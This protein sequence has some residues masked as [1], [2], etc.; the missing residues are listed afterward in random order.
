MSR[1]VYGWDANPLVDRFAYRCSNSSAQAALADDIA[2]EIT[3]GEGRRAI[4]L[5][6]PEDTFGI[7]EPILA[8]RTSANTILRFIKTHCQGDK[9]HYEI[10]HAGDR[11]T[12]ARHH[13]RRIRP[14]HR[15]PDEI[16][17]LQAVAAFNARVRPA[18]S[19]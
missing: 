15:T 5:Y 7:Y 16:W 18:I 11:S 17:V 8:V 2:F 4:Q 12:R 10:P 1:R 3:D 13:R 9:L 14:S 6:E 19:A